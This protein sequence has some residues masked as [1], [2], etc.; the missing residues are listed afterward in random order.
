MLKKNRTS[1]GHNKIEKFSRVS[2][3]NYVNK[4]L[5]YEHQFQEGNLMLDY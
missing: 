4:N 2:E 1:T 3:K 5:L